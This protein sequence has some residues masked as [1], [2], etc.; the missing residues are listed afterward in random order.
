MDD[1]H[2]TQFDCVLVIF[3][4]TY[5]YQKFF[6]VKVNEFHCLGPKLVL[7]HFF[8]LCE[9][10]ELVFVE[11][12]EMPEYA[13]FVYEFELLAVQLVLYLWQACL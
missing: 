12:A 4:A 1:G 9:F 10:Y 3:E 6:E 7:M 8:I 11:T 5:T 13:F 2:Q